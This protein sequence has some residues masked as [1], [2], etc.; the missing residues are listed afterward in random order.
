M[1]HMS[2]IHRLSK[3]LVLV[4]QVSE[5]MNMSGTGNIL[6]GIVIILTTKH[7]KTTKSV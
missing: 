3:P 5:F 4:I 1:S 7:T 6:G 2:E